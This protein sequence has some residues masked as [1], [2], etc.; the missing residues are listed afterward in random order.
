VSRCENPTGCDLHGLARETQTQTCLHRMHRSQ[1][2]ASPRP[3]RSF[4]FR[5]ASTFYQPNNTAPGSPKCDEATRNKLQAVINFARTQDSPC[6]IAPLPRHTPPRKPTEDAVAS[7]T[8]CWSL[9]IDC[10][11][12]RLQTACNWQCQAGRIAM[13]PCRCQQSSVIPLAVRLT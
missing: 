12:L 2:I 4:V 5:S 7:P 3:P 13:R 9:A 11:R 6:S 1:T 10:L 8:P